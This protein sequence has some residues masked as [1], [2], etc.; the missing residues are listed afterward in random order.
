MVLNLPAAVAAQ[1]LIQAVIALRAAIYLAVISLCLL[2]YDYTIT[3][4]QEVRFVWS[5]RWSFGKVVYIFIRY[6]TIIMMAG[7]VAS[8][9][10]FRPSVP[11]CRMI[12]IIF[13]W[14]Q[15][16]IIIAGSSVLVVR[17]WLLWGG[18]RWALA[19]LIGGLI[20]ASV[21]SIYFVYIDM[22]EFSIIRSVSP[23]LLP[24][25]LVRIPSTV[26][27]P[28]VPPL[29]YETFIMVLTVAKVS[30][31]PDR[32]PLMMRLFLDGTLYYIVVIM[33]LLLTTIGAM[34]T[35]TRPLV[36][37]SGFHTAC[38]SI[39][40]S[41]LV[42]SLHSWAHENKRLSAPH[43]SPREADKYKP[44][45][46]SNSSFSTSFPKKP[47]LAQPEYELVPRTVPDIE[48]GRITVTVNLNTNATASLLPQTAAPDV[49]SILP[50]VERPSLPE[51]MWQ[52]SS[53]H[54]RQNQRSHRPPRSS[55]LYP[56]RP[57]FRQSESM[58]ELTSTPER[59]GTRRGTNE[60]LL[61]VQRSMILH[62]QKKY[63]VI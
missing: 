2:V 51:R 13:V 40:C 61:G 28:F 4:D 17:T 55:S 45:R 46:S 57:T 34:Y 31:T 42:L 24:G 10:L 30:R 49:R 15:V 23:Q 35:P 32:A 36:I 11:L 14:S 33:A 26:W 27:R 59:E 41:R 18:V 25:C 7:H 21:L 53:M 48:S 5:Q 20:L 16:V 47:T 29:F 39:G 12:E 44:Y 62:T 8:M 52:S 37:G 22:E 6:A 54:T 56:A 43:S 3:I 58:E 38:I 63:N 60:T 50:D 19:A 1:A 9:F